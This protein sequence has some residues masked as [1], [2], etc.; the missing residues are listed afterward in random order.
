MTDKAGANWTKRSVMVATGLALATMLCTTLNSMPSWV[1]FLE[2]RGY[3]AAWL[4]PW[5]LRVQL[6][7]PVI[8][9]GAALLC[10]GS[11][12]W[13]L[14]TRVVRAVAWLR[15]LAKRLR[16]RLLWLVLEGDL[17]ARIAGLSRRGAEVLVAVLRV[18]ERRQDRRLF[19]SISAAEEL[20][21]GRRRGPQ[22]G[23]GGT[24][25]AKTG[26]QELE[27]AG[28]VERFADARTREYMV[29]LEAPVLESRVGG[30][31]VD[32][33]EGLLASRGLWRW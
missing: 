4:L 26:C 29:W 32:V 23:I 11:L 6:W 17:R 28:L 14:R 12:L 3:H 7:W 30:R 25:W 22:A 15:R 20:V 19:M 16:W 10:V 13:L 2:E 5:V 1:P 24:T 33:V 8:F 9:A 21:R 27:D 31:L 18:G